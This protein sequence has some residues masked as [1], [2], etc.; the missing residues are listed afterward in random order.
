[1]LSGHRNFLRWS[2]IRKRV[3]RFSEKIMPNQNKPGL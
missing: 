3:Q 2:M 1:M